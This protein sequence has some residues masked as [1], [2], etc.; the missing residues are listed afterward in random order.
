MVMEA[1]QSFRTLLAVEQC[2]KS[3][4]SAGSSTGRTQE[5]QKT[6]ERMFGKLLGNQGREWES[7][8]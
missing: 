1:V 8:P 5:K 4:Y 3:V 6:R 7:G 2:N